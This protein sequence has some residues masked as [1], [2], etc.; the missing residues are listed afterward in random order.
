MTVGLRLAPAPVKVNSVLEQATK[1][2]VGLD[3]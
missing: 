2:R 3:V 1:V